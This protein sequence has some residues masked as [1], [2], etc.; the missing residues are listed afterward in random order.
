[1]TIYNCEKCRD[2]GDIEIQVDGILYYKECECRE[3]AKYRTMLKKSGLEEYQKNSFK[4]YITKDKSKII[5]QA[6]ALA[7][8]YVRDFESIRTNTNNSIMLSGTPGCGKTHL[9][10][11][12]ANEIMDRYRVGVVYMQYREVITRIKQVIT[13]EVNYQREISLFKNSPVLLMDD[14][15]KGL[16]NKGIVN[17]SD[18]R[19]MFEIINHRYIN[20]KPIIVS[21]QCSPSEII[22]I[23]EAIGSRIYEMCKGRIV[24]FVGDDMNYRLR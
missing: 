9:S 7:I 1:V 12:I 20:R 19:I 11:A 15:Y 2:S 23:E 8:N 3:V 18:L 4:G 6:K 13:D 14:L 17:E 21:T 5:E 10:T 24:E 16:T 22:G